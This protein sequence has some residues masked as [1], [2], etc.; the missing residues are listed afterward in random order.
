MKK[1]LYLFAYFLL[2]TGC[3]KSPELSFV[4]YQSSQSTSCNLVIGLSQGSNKFEYKVTTDTRTTTGNFVKRAQQLTFSGL[5]AS[6]SGGNSEI[7]VSALID[8]DT[9]V[10]QNYGNSM[11]PFLLF[12]ECD[13]KYLSLTRVGS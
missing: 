4:Y 11:N 12:A 1:S 6:K 3:A 9:L 10:I 7:E 2:V 5:Y 8:G 13:D